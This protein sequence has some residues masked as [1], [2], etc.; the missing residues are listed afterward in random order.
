MS[1]AEII[2]VLESLASGCFENTIRYFLTFNL[3]CFQF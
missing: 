2:V 1:E 3:L